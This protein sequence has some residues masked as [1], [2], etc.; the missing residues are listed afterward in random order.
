[1][2]TS[3]HPVFGLMG[4]GEFLPWAEE[5]DRWLIDHA[6]TGSDRVLI[7]PTASAPEGD[8]VFDRWGTMGMEHYTR[9]GLKPEVVPIK[10]RDDAL[11]EDT[12]EAFA[13]AGLIFFSGGNPKYLVE[14][15]QD[16]PAW[17]GILEA[18]GAGTAF[19]GCSAGVA[20]LGEHAPDSA[21]TDFGPD[22]FGGG[23][24]YFTGV[25]FAPHWDA[26]DKYIPGLQALVKGALTPG[27]LHVLLDEDTAMV[28]DGDHFRVMGRGTITIVAGDEERAY[29]AGDSFSLTEAGAPA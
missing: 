25:E 22:S 29:R 27:F 16:T 2:S 8:E 1:V 3:E 6:R 23:L 26:L 7:L 15:F 12:A 5:V 19:G 18:L 21:R 9:M 17:R 4:S 10:T 20:F 14:V 28:G 24:A 13:G 11:R